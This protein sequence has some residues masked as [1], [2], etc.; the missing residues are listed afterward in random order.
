MLDIS[1]MNKPW[2]KFVAGAIW[3]LPGDAAVEDTGVVVASLE[4]LAAQPREYGAL[5]SPARLCH[6][7]D[8]FLDATNTWAII[9]ATGLVIARRHMAIDDFILK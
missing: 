6:P 9:L 2:Q 1:K 7:V 3:G 8:R 4:P 5:P